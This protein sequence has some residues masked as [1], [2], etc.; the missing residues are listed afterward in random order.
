M[1]R[2]RPRRSRQVKSS[3]AYN[4]TNTVSYLA[5]LSNPMAPFTGTQ[6]VNQFSSINCPIYAGAFPGFNGISG[7]YSEYKIVKVMYRVRTQF[8]MVAASQ[9]EEPGGGTNPVF[10]DPTC[11]VADSLNLVNM[12]QS[13]NITDI[14]CFSNAEL[15][16]GT[17]QSKWRTVYPTIRSLITNSNSP[18][19]PAVNAYAN[20]SGYISTSDPG[21]Q[22]G[23]AIL[24]G[25]DFL[26]PSGTYVAPGVAPK[27]VIEMRAWFKLRNLN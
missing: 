10:I 9:T 21:L 17:K 11:C 23:P 12:G 25:M 22:H 4:Q 5:V 1:S 6:I 8:N 14:L 26:S 27:V 24:I 19:S 16:R 7:M 3:T 2:S 20:T 15:F 13:M 18:I